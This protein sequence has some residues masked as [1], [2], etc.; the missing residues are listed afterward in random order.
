MVQ[1]NANF[2]LQTVTLTA[3]VCYEWEDHT[4]CR[5]KSHWVETVIWENETI[6]LTLNVGCWQ[7]GLTLQGL[8]TFC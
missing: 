8:S 7:V 4:R 1:L 2:M 5:F 3:F 6:M